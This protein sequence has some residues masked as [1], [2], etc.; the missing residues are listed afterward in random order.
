M[1]I[2]AYSPPNTSAIYHKTTTPPDPDSSFIQWMYNYYQELNQEYTQ[3]VK[4]IF[5]EKNPDIKDTEKLLNDIVDKAMQYE[6]E[7][8]EK[9]KNKYG[10]KVSE[11]LKKVK[12]IEKEAISEHLSNPRSS[13]KDVFSKIAYKKMSELGDFKDD[14]LDLFK[15]AKNNGTFN[16]YLKNLDIDDKFNSNIRKAGFDDLL[17]KGGKWLGLIGV[18]MAALE[19][20]NNDLETFERWMHSMG[21]EHSI[22][23]FESIDLTHIDLSLFKIDIPDIDIISRKNAERVT[24]FFGEYGRYGF[25]QPIEDYQWVFTTDFWKNE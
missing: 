9:L 7:A 14:A 13:L 19:F 23:F 25:Q 21:P 5:W 6:N 11:F 4:D 10:D 8:M 2:Q 20:Y 3:T 16:K 24:Y 22:K 1:S 17:S 12:T 18:A 15:D